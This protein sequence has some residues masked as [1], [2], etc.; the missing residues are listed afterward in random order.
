MVIAM[1]TRRPGRW[2]ALLVLGTGL[3]PSLGCGPDDVGLGMTSRPPRDCPDSELEAPLC[4]RATEAAQALNY[5]HYLLGVL[6]EPLDGVRP[7]FGAR[8][9][10]LSFALFDP[11]EADPVIVEAAGPFPSANTASRIASGDFD[12]DGD[13]E[14]AL[15]LGE[16]EQRHLVVLDGRTLQTEL[17]HSFE[18]RGSWGSVVALDVDGDDRP[19]LLTIPRNDSDSA[20]PL[21]AWA[22]RNGSLVE[23][24]TAAL[25][26]SSR[27]FVTRGDLDGDGRLDLAVLVSTHTDEDPAETSISILR[28]GSL[29]GVTL[30]LETHAQP[31]SSRGASAADLDADGDHELVLVHGPSTL[32]VID[33]SDDGVPSSEPLTLDIEAEDLDALFSVSTGRDEGRPDW[34]L[35]TG[36]RPSDPDAEEFDAA[37]FPGR[38][39][40]PVVPVGTRA[41]QLADYDD[42]GLSDFIAVNGGSRV[43]YLSIE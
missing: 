27:S 21:R 40:T 9:P 33:W 18:D 17:M 38:P 41:E 7:I 28:G 25:P 36:F 35:I 22:V 3:G 13:E 2:A 12:G 6:D 37:V 23:V 24:G 1:Q 42:D 11:R 26:R 5:E 15:V 10:E 16:L 19:E 30:P 39:G 43:V 4:H 31:A 20:L 34:L 14:I 29:E 8:L 32:S